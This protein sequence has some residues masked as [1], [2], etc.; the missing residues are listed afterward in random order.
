MKIGKPDGFADTS[1][2]IETDDADFRLYRKSFPK[3][4][5][6]LGGNTNASSDSRRGNYIVVFDRKILQPSDEPATLNSVLAAMKSANLNRGADLFFHHNGAGCVKCHAMGGATSLLAPDLSDIGNRA[7][8]PDTIIQSILDPSAAITEGFAQQQITTFDGK[9]ISGAVIE[10]TGQYLK[11]VGKDA[12]VKTIRKSD[13]EDRVSTKTSPMPAGFEKMMSS[14]QV[15]DLTAW[16]LTQK[17]VGDQQGFSFHDREQSTDIFFGKQCIATYL[18]KHEKLTRRA[19]VNVKTLSGIQV[20]RN[21]PPRNPE[22]I[23]PGYKGEEGIIHPVM[24][25]GIWIGF[26]DVNGNDYWRLKAHVE[27]NDF[28]EPPN[29][30]KSSGSFAISNRFMSEDG[31]RE[32][33]QELTRCRFERVPEGWLLKIDAEYK[34]DEHDF[35]FGDQEESGLAVRVASP[36]RVQGGNGTITNDRGEKN[37]KEVWGREAK[38]FNYS[39]TIEG[40]HVGVM[41]IP[42]P[43]NFRPSW[44]H[45]RDYGVVV[46]NPFPKQPKERREPYV[47]TWGKRGETLKLSWSVFIHESDAGSPL[48][49]SV[50]HSTLTTEETQP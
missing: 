34:S 5:I 30:G 9:V 1:M 25:P 48:D 29:G 18:K 13:I 11:L 2:I 43:D 45:A 15:A 24:H 20:T 42:S 19:F 37:G 36:I 12:N 27:F 38:W 21:F 22:D 28:V 49:P 46:T 33:C 50:F 41:V 39:G 16:L 44:L 3:G 26:G 8:T 14:Q 35:Y 17:R 10:E 7:E 47:K 4:K 23:D 40:R 31:K 32:V 6:V